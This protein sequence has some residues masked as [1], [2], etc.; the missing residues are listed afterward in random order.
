MGVTFGTAGMAGNAVSCGFGVTAMVGMTSV[1]CPGCAGMVGA[2]CGTE[3]QG[4]AGVCG[5]VVV[6]S[7]TV[8]A[9]LKLHSC[10]YHLVQQ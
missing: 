8:L 9:C 5:V 2:G 7:G 6:A 10:R 3:T 1:G 4:L